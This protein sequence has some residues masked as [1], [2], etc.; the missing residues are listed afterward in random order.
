MLLGFVSGIMLNISGKYM[1][2]ELCKFTIISP[3]NAPK[4]FSIV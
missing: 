4:V 1:V 3:N 2:L